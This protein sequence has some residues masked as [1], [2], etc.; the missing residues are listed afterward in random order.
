MGLAV[1][2]ALV[3]MS[4]L[5]AGCSPTTGEAQEQ[6]IVATYV[7]GTL[8]ALGTQE[9]LASQ[10]AATQAAESMPTQTPT[11]TLTVAPPT[12]PP[13]ATLPP[14]PTATSAPTAT[15]IPG[16]WAG[17]IK[18]VTVPDG[19]RMDPDES[20]TK[21]WRLKNIGSQRWTKQYELV[22]ISG[23]R[24]SGKKAIPLLRV[25]DP[26]ETVDLS[27]DLV[28]PLSSGR[29]KG[30]W[31]L[32]D[33]NGS[34]F[35]IGPDADDYFW[36][37]IRVVKEITRQ[38]FDFDA[39]YCDAAWGSAAGA[40]P[41]PGLVDDPAGSVVLVQ[42]PFMEDGRVHNGNALVLRPEWSGRGHIA[43][44]FP[45]FEVK[46]GDRLRM[47][48]SCPDDARRCDVILRVNYQIGSR[49]PERLYELNKAFDR[50][51]KW[52]DIN[53]SAL[54]G[55]NVKFILMLRAGREHVRGD[56]GILLNPGIW[57]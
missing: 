27:V 12:D 20:F 49:D 28:A 53:L 22:F 46:D 40:L 45:A 43:G 32:R 10:I 48:F 9:A 55:K 52:I 4:I 17:F 11:P 50:E 19:T 39:A 25:V 3:A 51:V 37:E 21:T 47:H 5:L 23:E 33:E 16:N 6:G 24:M 7:Q 29:Y 26:G 2:T 18:D 34:T 56:V 54:E 1:I 57:R 36:V 13:T 31:A 44:V 41:C 30:F 8:M 38:A 14:T 42:D 15:P 35:G